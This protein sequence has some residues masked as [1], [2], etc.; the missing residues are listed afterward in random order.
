VSTWTVALCPRTAAGNAPVPGSTRINCAWCDA[1]CWLSPATRD[2][3][4]SSGSRPICA[5]CLHIVLREPG[6][7]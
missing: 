2:A 7:S 6:N 3:M 1:E 5:A 4:Q